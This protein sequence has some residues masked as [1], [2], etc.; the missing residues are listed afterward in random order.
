M[1]VISNVLL[2]VLV[3]L[4]PSISLDAATL[5]LGDQLLSQNYMQQIEMKFQQLESKNSQLEEK[6]NQLESKVQKLETV[7][8][9]NV[10]LMTSKSVVPLTGRSAIARTCR[11][12]HL[13]DPSLE[14]GMHWI[15]PDGQG[16]GDDPIFV[17]CDMT[18]DTTSIPHDSEGP[19]DV[20]HCADPG[21]YSKS[22]S[23]NASSRQM[24]ALADLSVEC[25]QSIRYDCFYAPFEFGDV[26]YSW[27][28][29]QDGSAKY[30]WAGANSK[31]NH[32]CQCGIDGNCVE[33]VMKCNCDSTAPEQLADVGVISDKEILPVT[34]LNFGRTQRQYSSGVHTLGRLECTGQVAVTGMPTSCQDLWKIGHSLS[35]LYSIKGEKSVESV[36][37]DF[38]KLPTETGFQKWIG[39]DD[40]KS[41]PT[42]FYVQRN[43]AFST[44]NVPIPFQVSRLNIGNAMSLSTGKFTAPVRGTY[45][46]SFTGH[47]GF[48]T[49]SSL[50][51]LGVGLYVNGNY[52]G[53]GFVEERDTVIWQET[54]LT[55]QS[56]LKLQKG[57]QVWLQIKLI[58]AGVSLYDNGE[59][60]THFSGYIL[61]E[62]LVF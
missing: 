14:S 36:Y 55:L 2:G 60:W 28:N 6:V 9:S 1:I 42:Y 57:D 39:Y 15:D 45:F 19:M 34:G 58:S 43:T 51:S 40:I 62:E 21:C 44:I 22:I 10:D 25:H 59:I 61:G 7:I 48:P 35:G 49:S 27:W 50:L 32:T 54:P 5:N 33:P 26:V 56:T 3:F 20:G 16:V 41:V 38:S 47:A 12:A 29:D 4:L 8:A 52:I 13:A 23:Y 17:Y 37:C 30:F 24:A 46:F 11:E 53:W 18:T 31:N